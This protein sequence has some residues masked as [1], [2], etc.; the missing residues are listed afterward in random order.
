MALQKSLTTSYRVAAEY[1]KVGQV[2]VDWH[3]KICQVQVLGFYNAQARTDLA[4]ILQTK[5]FGWNGA[6]FTFDFTQNLLAQ[7]YAKLKLEPEF[8]EAVD[9]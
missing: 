6:S 7:I 9:V 1:W 8:L 4:E 2:K 3:N 5:V